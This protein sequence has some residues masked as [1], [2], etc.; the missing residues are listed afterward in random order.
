M[1]KRIHVATKHKVEYSLNEYGFNYG[2][3]SFENLMHLLDV[4]CTC[5]TDESGED[6]RMEIET[7]FLKKAIKRMKTQFD[8]M[9]DADEID[10]IIEGQGLTRK[11]MI[12]QL[13]R[14]VRDA[15][16]SNGWMYITWY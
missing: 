11:E 4:P 2:A 10:G 9:L 13:E 7:H 15:D 3:D 12:E 6:I 16:S 1:G 5:V 8:G 14:M